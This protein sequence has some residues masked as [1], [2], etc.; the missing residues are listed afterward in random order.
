M[1]CLGIVCYTTTD[2]EYSSLQESS[3]YFCGVLVGHL[4][5]DMLGTDVLPPVPLVLSSLLMIAALI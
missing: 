1:L 2:N 3:F 4:M 5:Q